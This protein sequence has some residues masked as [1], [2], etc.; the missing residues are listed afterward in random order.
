MNANQHQLINRIMTTEVIDSGWLD[1]SAELIVGSLL[2][3]LNI[4]RAGIWLYNNER[5]EYIT[6]TL[7]I[8]QHHH[9]RDNSTVLNRSDFPT[10]FDALDKEVVIVANDTFNDPVT[11]EF[12]VGYL[13][14]LNITSMLDAPIRISGKTVGVVC[15]ENIGPQKAWSNDE[16]LFTTLLADQFGR[17]LAAKEKIAQYQELENTSKALSRQTA[18]LKALHH[19]LDHFSLIA[20]FDRNGIISD[21]NG[22]YLALSKFD[23][24]QLIGCS[25]SIF[26][27]ELLDSPSLNSMW[28]T[29][30]QGKI[31]QGIMKQ[32]DK[33]K[34]TFWLNAT[35][36]PVKNNIGKTEGY[37]GFFHNITHEMKMENQLYQAEQMAQMGSFSYD[38]NHQEWRVSQNLHNI[39][40]H[41]TQKPFNWESLNQTL[42]HTNLHTLHHYFE[43]LAG[44]QPGFKSQC[45]LHQ[46][47]RWYQFIF[48]RHKQ[49]IIGSCQDI[50][51][52]TVQQRTLDNIILLQNTI[53]DSANST[54]IATNPE[55]LITHFN[56]TAETV[57]QYQA[58]E[59]INQKSPCLF[60]RIDEIRQN[61]DSLLPND[62]FNL[63]EKADM[64]GAE[65][66]EYHYLTKD[67]QAI[68]MYLS[69][70]AIKNE[71]EHLLGY[72]F[73]GRD[74]RAQ[75]AVERDSERLRS[76]METAGDIAAFSGYSY[77]VN[78]GTLHLTHEGFKQL[79]SQQHD[80]KAITVE[81]ALPLLIDND[82]SKVLSALENAVLHTTDFDIKVAVTQPNPYQIEWLRIVGR[83]RSEYQSVTS[84][85][86]FIQDISKQNQLESKLSKQAYSDELTQL[87]N[88]RWLMDY[89]DT[90]W[91]S[92][93]VQQTH[94]AIILMDIDHFKKV[95]DQWGHDAG[96]HALKH[97][98][99]TITPHLPKE[100][101]FGRFG[102]EE[103]MIVLNHCRESDATDLAE[104]IRRAL[105]RST[106]FYTAPL[107]HESVTIPLTVSLGVSSLENTPI[108]TLT[109]WLNS[110]DEALYSAKDSGRNQVIV[111]Q[112]SSP[113]SLERHCIN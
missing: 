84:I 56:K 99:L 92:H 24:P 102:G 39:F 63:V 35:V 21:I 65:E 53:L 51:Q 83:T 36:S 47:G 60:H 40:Q 38:L 32:R 45:T 71:T 26:E 10:Y 15:C 98:A 50:T 9:V 87:A 110:A 82:R 30:H 22:N 27:P 3:G 19:S 61:A 85:I 42:S 101:L 75:K 5:C 95:N 109:Q 96:D 62:F 14:V 59:V 70:T 76:I 64:S 28:E 31:W 91:Q 43:Q 94:P 41:D 58:D 52:Q 34:H 33:D 113:S 4:H 89:L 68:P 1:Q 6:A 69:I 97:L 37:I 8:D 90:I 55:G 49:S 100:S 25:L 79:I 86:G 107:Q 103:F 93:F 23:K 77:D 108:Q 2:S 104:N 80:K 11:C 105:E 88:R 66:K 106:C 20:N 12:T 57:L 73:I 7:V 78:D 18:Q 13:D 54:I 111:Y 74:L 29:L 72:L 112:D 17:A 67:G 46:K 48:Q 81:D 44:Q 16:I